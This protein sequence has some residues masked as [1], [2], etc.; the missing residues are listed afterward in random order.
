MKYNLTAPNLIPYFNGDG[1][2][3]HALIALGQDKAGEKAFYSGMQ[4]IQSE[5]IANSKK[6]NDESTELIECDTQVD[7]NENLLIYWKN[8][9]R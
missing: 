9:K 8:K 6:I 1:R 2:Y 5:P 7:H 4:E 3:L